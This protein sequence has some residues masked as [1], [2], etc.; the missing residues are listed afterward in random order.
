MC[1]VCVWLAAAAGKAHI[2]R[3]EDAFAVP[4]APPCIAVIVTFAAAAAAAAA[5]CFNLF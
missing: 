1:E 5:A 3:A 4:L 2:S